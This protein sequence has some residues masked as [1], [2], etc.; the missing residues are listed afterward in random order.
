[1]AGDATTDDVRGTARP[2][3]DPMD[4]SPR[5]RRSVILPARGDGLLLRGTLWRPE[6]NPADVRGVITIHGGTGRSEK[7]YEPMAK[8][9]TERGYAVVTYCY[10][11]MERSGLESDR[12]NDT[13]SMTDWITQDAPGVMEWA[14]EH[15]PD[16]PAYALGHGTG[17]HG[18][19]WAGSEGLYDGAVLLGVGTRGLR[20]ISGLANRAK[21]F[22]LLTVVCPVTA[23]TM[24]RIPRQPFGFEVEPPVGV[25][26]QWA[27]WARNRDYFFGDSEHDFAA[28]YARANG[29]YLSVRILDDEWCNQRGSDEITDRMFGASVEKRVLEP[30][31][32]E[33]GHAGVLAAGNEALFDGFVDWFEGK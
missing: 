11:G 5:P 17:G 18:V 29:R 26:R 12:R 13:M 33:L 16:V 24:G 7:T 20:A 8:R 19:I 23:E 14:R 30:G 27:R 22:S 1:M 31:D 4:R 28:R 32:G 25:V 2:V 9:F 15:F 6:E 3:N 21:L 10:R